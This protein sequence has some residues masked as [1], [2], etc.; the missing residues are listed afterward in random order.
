[1]AGICRSGREGAAEPIILSLPDT[2]VAKLHA[3]MLKMME[4]SAVL[5]KLLD[6]G[7]EPGSS[8]PEEFP[9]LIQ[10]ELHKWR[11]VARSAGLKFE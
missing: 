3:A 11:N 8:S 7:T 4:T 1:M 9:K 6:L 10:D 2:V 5:A